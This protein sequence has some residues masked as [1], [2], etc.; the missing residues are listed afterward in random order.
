MRQSS[1][2]EVVEDQVRAIK[3]QRLGHEQ[4]PPILCFPSRAGIVTQ[5]VV[6]LVKAHLVNTETGRDII[7]CY[8]CA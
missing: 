8:W 6:L 5:H 7:S 2:N 4:V 1:L 3:L